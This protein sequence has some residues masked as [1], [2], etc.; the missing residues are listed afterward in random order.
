MHIRMA[1]SR[2]ISVS[3]KR[4]V[5]GVESD[6]CRRELSSGSNGA[7]ATV[8]ACVEITIAIT[9]YFFPRPGAHASG[10]GEMQTLAGKTRVHLRGTWPQAG[11]AHLLQQVQPF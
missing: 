5:Q 9:A 7:A 10:C 8:P 2:V 4:I 11:A 3:A 1:G 6:G